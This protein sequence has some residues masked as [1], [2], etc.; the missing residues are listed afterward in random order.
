MANDDVVL[1]ALR[2]QPG[3]SLAQIARDAGWLD[4]DDQPEKWRVQRAIA[5]L[6]DDK[7]IQKPGRAPPGSSQRRARKSSTRTTSSGKPEEIV[8]V[9]WH[10]SR[11]PLLLRIVALL[12]QAATFL[13]RNGCEPQKSAV[14]CCYV[15]ATEGGFTPPTVA[16]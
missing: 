9:A 6:T 3:Q 8:A 10:R 16:P 15:A 12:R 5:S 13:L 7:L 2:N 4:D 1:R 11:A 14:F